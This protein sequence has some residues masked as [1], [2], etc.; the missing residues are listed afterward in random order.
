MSSSSLTSSTWSTRSAHPATESRP[1]CRAAV[2]GAVHQPV[3]GALLQPDIP[4]PAADQEHQHR[5]GRYLHCSL[6]AQANGPAQEQAHEGMPM[7]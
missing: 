5:A 6:R 2:R 3:E 4:Q 1:V 7:L